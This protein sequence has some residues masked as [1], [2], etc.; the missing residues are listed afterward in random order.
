MEVSDSSILIK[1][2][3]IKSSFLSLFTFA[4]WTDYLLMFLGSS[5]AIGMGVLQP[6]FF[7]LMSSFFNSMGPDSTAA[8]FYDNALTVVYFLIGLG[9][10]LSFAGWVAV[11]CWVIVGARQAK[12]FREKYFAAILNSDPG[13]LDSKNIAKLPTSISADT[14]KIERAA[15]DKLVIL[16]FTFS[17][18]LAAF[19]MGLILG[20]Q[21]TLIA[22]CFSPIVVG[23]LVLLNK[24]IE[25]SAKASDTSYKK[26]SG[27]AEEALQEIK[28]VA[29]LIRQN[30]ETRKYIETLK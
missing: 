13:T 25:Q 29:S 17:M 28:T 22:F 15:G 30:Y 12:H 2:Q 8:E 20:T 16:I 21:L 14:L 6:I 10:L 24:G 1:D 7:L 4:T 3:A 9:F 18:I 23:G 11:M 19:L 5:G 27:V 26:S